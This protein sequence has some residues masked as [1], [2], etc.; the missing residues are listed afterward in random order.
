M[1]GWNLAVNIG[2]S[3]RQENISGVAPEVLAA[4]VQQ[5]AEWS[6]QQKS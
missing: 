5:N 3:N 6:E 1:S 2:G 4:I